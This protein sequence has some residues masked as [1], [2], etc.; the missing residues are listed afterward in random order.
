MWELRVFVG[1]VGFCGGI[2]GT[3][4]WRRLQVWMGPPWVRLSLQN[5]RLLDIFVDIGGFCG[6]YRDIVRDIVGKKGP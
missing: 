4:D 1:I 2:V 6:Y 5:L 3:K